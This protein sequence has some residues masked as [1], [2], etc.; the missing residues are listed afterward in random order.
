MAI[1]LPRLEEAFRY[2]LQEFPALPVEL[3]ELSVPELLTRLAAEQLNHELLVELMLLYVQSRNPAL[4]PVRQLF[5]AEEEAASKTDRLS[6]P[7]AAARWGHPG[8]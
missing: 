1:A 3:R 5:A 8:V 7:V 2:Y 4:S 6:R